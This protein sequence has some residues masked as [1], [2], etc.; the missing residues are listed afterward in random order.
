MKSM[1]L[2]SGLSG[3][4]VENTQLD[5]ILTK[6]LQEITQ[7]PEFKELKFL[8]EKKVICEK[9]KSTIFA[10]QK[11]VHKKIAEVRE[12][13]KHG[14]Y[15]QL[16]LAERPMVTEELEIVKAEYARELIQKLFVKCKSDKV[17]RFWLDEQKVELPEDT[18]AMA[19]NLGANITVF[20]YLKEKGF[21]NELSEEQKTEL[22]NR[23]DRFPG[24]GL[25]YLKQ[26]F[27]KGN[28]ALT[29]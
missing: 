23:A 11:E 3:K 27:L 4:Q 29:L 13:L 16:I 21:F 17:L 9:F 8:G 15:N 19:V 14:K 25:E 7:L 10:E 12:N 6:C 18:W 5:T 20:K 28:T 2:F 22:L 24:E 1:T 26:E